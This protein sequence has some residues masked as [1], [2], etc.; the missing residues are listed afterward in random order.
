VNRCEAIRRN[1]SFPGRWNPSEP[2]LR[3]RSF[4]LCDSYSPIDVIGLPRDREEPVAESRQPEK[5]DAGDRG[6]DGQIVYPSTQRGRS[7]EEEKGRAE[8]S[9][10]IALLFCLVVWCAAVWSALYYAVTTLFD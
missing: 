10:G 8:L 1:M 4:G 5:L 7:R 9:R 2:G 6:K 3:R